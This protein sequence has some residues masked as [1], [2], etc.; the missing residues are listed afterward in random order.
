LQ[1]LSTSHPGSPGQA[2]ENLSGAAPSIR[3]GIELQRSGIAN[4]N[5]WLIDGIDNNE[6]TFNT[7][8]VTPQSSRYVSSRY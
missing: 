5:G 6:Y 1:R 2:G 7:V 3:A 4:A 8:I